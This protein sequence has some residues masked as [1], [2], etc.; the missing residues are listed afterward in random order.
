MSNDH[1]ELTPEFQQLVAYLSCTNSKFWNTVAAH[2]DVAA[3]SDKPSRKVL[4]AIE[5]IH[6]ASGTIPANPDVVCQHITSQASTGSKKFSATDATEAKAFLDAIGYDD[7]IT[8]SEDAKPILNELVIQIKDRKLKTMTMSMIDMNAK[9]VGDRD[10]A[11]YSKE[12][13]TIDAI[14]KDG[15]S[16]SVALN[17]NFMEAYRS[18]SLSDRTP[19]GIAPLDEVMGGGMGKGLCYVVMGTG[20]GKCH[21][22]GTKVLMYKGG[23]KSI[24]RVEKGDLMMGPDSTPRKVLELCRGK[25]SI[26]EIKMPGYGSFKVTSDHLVTV[27]MKIDDRFVLT[28]IPAKQLA[29][30]KF[31]KRFKAVCAHKVVLDKQDLDIDRILSLIGSNKEVPE[32]LV[33]HSSF[34]TRAKNLELLKKEV[35]TAYPDRLERRVVRK[36]FT[37]LGNSVGVTLEDVMSDKLGNKLMARAKDEYSLRDFTIEFISPEENYYGVRVDRDARYLLSNF[38]V[39]HNS[40]MLCHMSAESLYR[41]RNVAYATLELPSEMIGGRVFSN[42]MGVTKEELAEDSPML[43]E[44]MGAVMEH[45]GEMHIR[46]FKKHTPLSSIINWVDDLEKEGIVIDVLFL[47]MA[48]K[49]GSNFYAAKKG[50]TFDKY[51]NEEEVASEVREWALD[52]DK[53]VVTADQLVKNGRNR[54]SADPDAMAGSSEKSNEADVILMFYNTN[55]EDESTPIFNVYISKDRY[56]VSGVKLT[57]ISPDYERCRLEEKT[58]QFGDHEF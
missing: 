28:D 26:Y 18:F 55:E 13:Q 57:G 31:L 40:M 34:A 54:D 16:P 41:G 48:R 58:R 3:F 7:K 52:R 56:G 2:I 30:E 46:F 5:A 12:M 8:C 47:D 50:Q 1:Y 36:L 4:E 6:S 37:M 32:K 38:I 33:I 21:T 20:V 11:K 49:V 17:E 45:I 15:G 25:D 27:S 53:W 19:T 44:R 22:K 43:T 51:R 14:G 29:E 10:L 35:V 24:E 39:T 9:P 42:L 23:F